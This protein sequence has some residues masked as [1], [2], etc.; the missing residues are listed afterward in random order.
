M[1]KQYTKRAHARYAVRCKFQYFVDGS[2][3]EGTVW[4]LSTSGWRASGNQPVMVGMEMAVCLFLDTEKKW[5]SVEQVAVRWVNGSN[6]GLEIL[7]ID[8]SEQT[9]LE[10]FIEQSSCRSRRTAALAA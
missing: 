5:V 2:V 3:A 4:D 8:E 1:G 7:K 6:F 9:R 10:Q